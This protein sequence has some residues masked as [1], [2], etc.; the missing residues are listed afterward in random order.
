MR[1]GQFIPGYKLV[2]A[3]DLFRR[4]SHLTGSPDFE[5]SQLP[6]DG[7]PKVLVRSLAQMLHLLS[8]LVPKFSITAECVSPTTLLVQLRGL[9]KPY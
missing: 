9:L 1:F 4:A 2:D 7:P 3:D 6:D 8:G 5:L